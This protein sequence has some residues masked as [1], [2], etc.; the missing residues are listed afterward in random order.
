M[1]RARDDAALA[2][3]LIGKQGTG[4][5]AIYRGLGV[6]VTPQSRRIRVMA[7]RFTW[8]RVRLRHE[9]EVGGDTAKQ[10]RGVSWTGGEKGKATA[11]WW[12]GHGWFGPREEERE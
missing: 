9:L 2:L 10:A 7:L 3:G 8:T 12:L 4:A 1:L 5:A 6:R 11:H